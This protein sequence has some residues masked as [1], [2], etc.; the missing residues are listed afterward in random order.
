MLWLYEETQP[1]S[2]SPADQL[3]QITAAL[4]ARGGWDDDDPATKPG[5]LGAEP[6]ADVV[7]FAAVRA[8]RLGDGGAS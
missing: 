5:G 4:I 7:D 1:F 2:F 6:C 3:T 8:A